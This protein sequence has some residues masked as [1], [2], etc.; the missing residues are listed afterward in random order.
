MENKAEIR[1]RYLEIRNQIPSDERAKK[2]AAIR[3]KLEE[4]DEFR[5]AE[6]ILFYY[7]TGS[8]VD[9]IPMINKWIKEKRIYLPRLISPRDFIALP[10]SNFEALAKN[11]F[12]IPEPMPHEA[13]KRFE[14]KLDL[15]IVPGVAFG[16][17]GSRLGMGKGFYDR[18][19]AGL[20]D[21]PRI[22][23]AY[24]DQML[25]RLPKEDYDENINIIIT[26]EDIYQQKAH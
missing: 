13:E 18:Y 3:K 20:K 7:A 4:L 2:A 26:D 23:L 17:D 1:G 21:L 9:T 11:Q 22:G 12:Q 10:F 24:E 6:H 25:D 19:L 8:E 5:D 14:G 15:V 16:K